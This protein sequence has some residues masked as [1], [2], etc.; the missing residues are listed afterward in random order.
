MIKCLKGHKS[1]ELVCSIFTCICVWISILVGQVLS[2]ELGV[3]EISLVKLSP[4]SDL[5]ER[6]IFRK[7][8]RITDLHAYMF[9]SA[10]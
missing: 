5:E 6:K 3:K 2:L 4:R 10:S 8:V 9:F 7:V 1:P